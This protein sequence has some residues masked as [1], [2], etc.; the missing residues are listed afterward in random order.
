MSAREPLDVGKGGG[1]RLLVG[2]EQQKIGD[3]QVIQPIG[4]GRVHA[5]AIQGVA[6]H[7]DVVDPGV[8]ERLDPEMVA[9]AEEALFPGV[10]DGEREVAEQMIDAA[11]APDAVGV[12]DQLHVRVGQRGTATMPRQRVDQVR[13][14]VDARVGRDPHVPIKAAGLTLPCRFLGGAQ[15]GMAEAYGAVGPGFLGI[16]TTERQDV[17][18]LLQEQPIDRGAVQVED[19]DDSAHLAL[20]PPSKIMPAKGEYFRLTLCR[21]FRGRPSRSSHACASIPPGALRTPRRKS[22]AI[23]SRR[24]SHQSA[25]DRERQLAR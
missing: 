5:H 13:P 2:G 1:R 18:H 24:S 10:P 15:Q 21:S 14:V 6:E 12:Q 19:P 8:E 25:S 20:V 11:L 23:P 9:G 4:N 22:L 3:R 7:Q 17:G 16:G